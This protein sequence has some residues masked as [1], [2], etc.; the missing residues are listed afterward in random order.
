[1]SKDKEKFP[2][3][4]PIP[5]LTAGKTL[6]VTCHPTLTLRCDIMHLKLSFC[7]SSLAFRRCLVEWSKE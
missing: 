1:M 5:V 3:G 7:V 4:Q 6:L 2:F